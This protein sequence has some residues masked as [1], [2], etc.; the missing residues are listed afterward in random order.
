MGGLTGM[1]IHTLSILDYSRLR[2]DVAGFCMSG[3]GRLSLEQRLPSF[4]PAQVRRLKRLA[5]EWTVFIRSGLPSS[6]EGWPELG[7]FPENSSGGYAVPGDAGPD[8][9]N[10]ST[11]RTD[12][13]E[14]RDILPLL[15]VEGAALSVEEL[16]AL[17]LFCRSSIGL[18]RII[19]SASAHINIPSLA[20]E[21]ALVPPLEEPLSEIFRV[22]DQSGRL[23]D[24]GELRA[25][26][27]SIRNIRRD[28]ENMMRRYTS[29][30][31]LKNALQSDVPTIR[32]GRQVLAVKAGFR[33]RVKGL[34]HEVSQ[35][36]QTVYIEPDDVVRRNND[37]IQE[38]YR[39]SREIQR[40]LRELTARLGRWRNEFDCARERMV[41]LDTVYA[42]ASWGVG[43]SC[44]FAAEPDVR[45]SEDEECPYFSLVQARHP[46]LGA[47]AVPIDLKLLPGTRVLIVTGA[48]TGGKTVSLKTAALFALLNQSGFPVPAG[49][50]TVLPLFD[51]VYA[52]IGDDQSLDESLS[53]FSGHMKNIAGIVSRATRGSLV[54]LDELGSGTDPQEGSA[55]AMAVLDTFIE[56]GALVL[57]TTHHGALKNYG[58]VHPSCAN[59]SVEFDEHTLSPTYRILMGVPGESH[60]LDIASRSGLPP[61]IV[62]RAQR[63]LD[64]SQADVSV[65]IKSLTEK[66]EKLDALFVR[67]E[68]E[69]K[70]VRERRRK[71]D[72]KELRLRRK[73]LEL[74]EQ[75][76]RHTVVFL[77][78]SRRMLEN[79]VR[80]LREGEITREKTL[81]VKETI[82]GLSRS[83]DE[84]KEAVMSARRDLEQLEREYETGF[85]EE[86]A[87]PPP[88]SGACGISAAS[89]ETGNVPVYPD[90]F[91]PGTDVFVGKTRRRGTLVREDRKGS[92]IVCIGD[93]NMTVKENELRLAPLSQARLSVSVAVPSGGERPAAELNL[94]GMRIDEARKA[95]ERQMDLAALCGLSSFSVIHGKG[96]GV[97]QQGVHEYLKNSSAVAE[98]CFARPEEGGTGK[99]YVRLK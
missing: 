94:R 6:P 35:T 42:A 14:Q 89:A 19:R 49:E 10:A 67:Q 62:G 69:I 99:T 80:E 13:T 15:S 76:F 18:T 25:I 68:R 39:L 36:G 7:G 45:D 23:R 21:A 55:V 46:L 32:N 60:A 75:G 77:D 40:I 90:R 70:D 54:V 37:L 3:E 61:D 5:A 56:K 2:T 92:W 84:E 97:L 83:A 72:L 57:T 17:G 93:M 95:L 27:E 73:E 24:L 65:L 87:G 4:D 79:L 28:T 82:A 8:R 41:F 20:E 85:E 64:G 16:Y 81:K 48:N 12:R 98:Y 38:E 31:S 11:V 9:E 58:Y 26:R 51:G 34:I 44:V 71:T 29:D 50:G 63:Y 86:Q 74:Q 96:D 43:H 33:G 59:A 52:D 22:I 88:R 91:A 78:D 30:S 66:H 47:R 1:D 53:T